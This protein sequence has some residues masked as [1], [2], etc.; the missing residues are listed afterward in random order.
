MLKKSII[1][2]GICSKISSSGVYKKI[3]GFIEGAKK[4]G[5][6]GHVKAIEPNGIRGYMEF[7]KA[8]C[9]AKESNVI[10]RYIPKLGIVLLF[11]GIILRITNRNLIIDVPTPMKNHIKEILN[12]KIKLNIN[13][14]LHILIIYLQAFLPFLS[15]K[16]IIHYAKDS[17]FFTFGAKYKVV[18]IG[19]GVDVDSIPCRVCTPIWPDQKLNLVAVGTIAFW[20]GWDKIIKVIKELKEEEFKVF[21]ILLTF[22]GEGPELINLKKMVDEYQLN[23]FV[24]FKGHLTGSDLYKEY[25]NAHI[26]LGS[27]GWSRIDL[28]MASPIKS[29]EYIAAGMPCLYSTE[30]IDFNENC[31]FAYNVSDSED[32]N[33]MKEFIKNLVNIR[34][35]KSSECRKFATDN[36]DFKN[37]ISLVLN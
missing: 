30:D 20:H 14:Y 10:V 4:N 37:K 24:K 25:E 31:I 8:I 1:Y 13:D 26:G 11:L 3:F 36:L 27:L 9:F 2:I 21:D 33:D 12:K 18:I 16:K 23:S 34:L 19:N 5:F 17:A 29:R 15:A 22:I 28:K 7:V 35:P 32:I 6:Q